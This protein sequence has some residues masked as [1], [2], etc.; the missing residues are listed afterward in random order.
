MG[1]N[2][3]P[4][5]NIKA[6]INLLSENFDP[7]IHSSIWE[8]PA[9]GSSGPNYLNSAALFHSD[10][11][12]SQ[13]KKQI[14]TPLENRLGRVRSEDKYMDRTID[15]DTLVYNQLVID[16]ELWE[17]VHLALPASEVCPDLKNPVSGETLRETANKLQK[18]A[19]ILQRFD[20]ND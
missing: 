13:I 20:L 5:K 17:Q 16:S 12:L 7:L 6:A 18:K 10:L 1:S 9:V 3:Q 8:S 14:L 19:A 15:L 11:S 4:V 2:I